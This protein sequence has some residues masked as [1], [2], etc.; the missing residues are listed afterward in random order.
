MSM[1]PEEMISKVENLEIQLTKKTTEVTV[2]KTDVDALNNREVVSKED[3]EKLQTKFEVTIE[4]VGKLKEGEDSKEKFKTIEEQ[5]SKELKDNSEK[6]KTALEGGKDS[7]Y[8]FKVQTGKAN[9]TKALASTASIT[10]NTR[11]LYLDGIGMF[12]NRTLGL[13]DAVRPMTIDPKNSHTSIK[14]AD[15]DESQRVLNAAAI[16]EGAAFPEDSIGFIEK[17]IP[18]RKIGTTIPMTEEIMTDASMFADQIQKSLEIS[19]KLAVEQG[20]YNGP[21]TGVTLTGFLTSISPYTA[22]TD[23]VPT[24]NIF[25]LLT[26]IRSRITVTAGS[27]YSPMTA[28]MNISDIDSLI[29]AKDN[30]GRYLFP[31]LK[32]MGG[33]MYSLGTLMIMESNVVV[34]NTLIFGDMRFAELHRTNEA[35]VSVGMVNNQF[36]EDELTLK[37]KERMAMIIR[38]ADAGGFRYVANITTELATLVS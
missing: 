25:D 26:K 23:R 1:T 32:N 4:E 22:G 27:K 31:E 20:M 16:A 5:L 6:F 37:V 11:A 34:A 18:I 36:N 10:D 29:L 7:T 35:M 21:G 28:L 24:A 14:Y 13:M 2:L 17:T 33:G 12:A 8:S 3:F 30:E 38:F 9:A 19:V 15:W